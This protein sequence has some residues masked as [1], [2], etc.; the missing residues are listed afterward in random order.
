MVEDRVAVAMLNADVRLPLV[1]DLDQTLVLTDTLYDDYQQKYVDAMDSLRT[2]SSIDPGDPDY[3]PPVNT[4]DVLGD[5]PAPWFPSAD[6]PGEESM[7]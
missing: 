6:M 7:L 3:Q 1:I 5:M 4:S 2:G